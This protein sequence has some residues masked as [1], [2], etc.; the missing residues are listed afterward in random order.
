MVSSSTVLYVFVSIILGIFSYMLTGALNIWWKRNRQEVTHRGPISIIWVMLR[1]LGLTVG[2]ITVILLVRELLPYEITSAQGVLKSEGL[3]P[4]KAIDRY[5]GKL[6]VKNGVVNKSEPLVSYTRKLGPV[7]ESEALLQRQMLIEQIAE[8]RLRLNS[9]D[10]LN[11]LQKLSQ[12]ERLRAARELKQQSRSRDVWEIESLKFKLDEQTSHVSLARKEMAFAQDAIRTGLISKIEY[13]RRQ[14]KLRM[15][16]LRL[17][18]MK[19]RLD[20]ALGSTSDT[21]SGEDEQSL[22]RFNQVLDEGITDV[23]VTAGNSVLVDLERRL[24]ELD[25]VLSGKPQQPIVIEAPWSGTIGYS[26]PSSV[27]SARD[28]IGVLVQPDSLFV[29]VLVPV[30]LTDGIEAGAK[31]EVTNA[32]LRDLGVVLSGRLHRL[33]SANP[34]QTMLD[35]RLEH[36]SD[37]IRDL[38]LNREVKLTVSFVNQTPSFFE[39]S[40]D[41]LPQITSVNL[42]LIVLVLLL[43][44]LVLW[45][46]WNDRSAPTAKSTNTKTGE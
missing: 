21:V 38:A 19:S 2:S 33:Q 3:F 37:L 29:E 20:F 15:E 11:E 6:E 18:E 25:H 46:W 4:V 5:Q 7:E 40:L 17:K 10:P 1:F 42:A 22:S 44:M 23:E 34:E 24:R 45:R 13:D 36:R 8:L 41:Y 12:V 39:D 35:I 9:N 28:L 30:N 26:N 14:Q 27:L 31:I 43:A 16:E 32:N